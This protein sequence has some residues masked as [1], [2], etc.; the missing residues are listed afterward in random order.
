MDKMTPYTRKLETALIDTGKAVER[1]Q[2]EMTPILSELD[3]LYDS[4]R[5][6]LVGDDMM[7]QIK[8]A[9]ALT[10]A[11]LKWQIEKL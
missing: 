5:Q 10:A 4:F 8:A 6:A 11:I 3:I 9:K 7:K 1:S 2:A